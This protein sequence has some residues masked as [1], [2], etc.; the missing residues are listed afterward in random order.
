[1]AK[2]PENAAVPTR[3]GVMRMRR[4][5]VAKP[6]MGKTIMQAWPKP[7]GKQ[8][9]E[10]Q[11][12]WVERFKYWACITKS[13]DAQTYDQAK[14]WAKDTGWFWRD[15]LTSAMAGKLISIIGETKIT[16]PTV[17]ANRITN[18]ALTANVERDVPMSACVWDNNL[19]WSASPNPER[20]VFKAPGLYLVGWS[21]AFAGSATDNHNYLRLQIGPTGF[22]PYTTGQGILTQPVFLNSGSI[23]YF[24][25]EDYVILRAGSNISQNLT[26]AV[27]WAVA[28]TPE[29]IIP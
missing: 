5:V 22:L 28:I 23:W 14:A 17:Y 20:I 2:L 18:L 6:H 16:T 13:P 12:A 4:R 27:L 11:K 21:G 1:M 3:A 19:F 29:A 9:S 26:H 24:H 15:V 8:M 10:R 25:A 7:R